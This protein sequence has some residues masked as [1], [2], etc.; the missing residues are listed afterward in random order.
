MGRHRTNC[1]RAVRGLLSVVR[2][3]AQRYRRLETDR[4]MDVSP[5][6]KLLTESAEELDEI[7]QKM[8]PAAEDGCCLGCCPS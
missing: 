1:R 2:L 5:M 8:P 4:A 3:T 7:V 6:S